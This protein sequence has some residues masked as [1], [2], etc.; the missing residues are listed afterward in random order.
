M[1]DIFP[2]INAIGVELEGGWN[3]I[4]CRCHPLEHDG[5]VRVEADY[6]TGEIP[7]GPLYS[8]TQAETEIR[9][10]YPHVTNRT[11]GLHVHLSFPT[12]GHYSAIMSPRFEN[13]LHRRLMLYGKRKNFS[14]DGQFFQRLTGRN[15]YCK[16]R[17]TDRN[18]MTQARSTYK[19]GERYAFLNYCHG[20]HGTVELR[21]LPAFLRVNSALRAIKY[22]LES[23][24][25]FL[26]LPGA[27]VPHVEED[28]AYMPDAADGLADLAERI[29]AGAWA[30][31]LR[32]EV[33]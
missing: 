20:L 24:E 7:L 19:G 22:T 11:C 18:A 23:F 3:T 30:S 26:S 6:A 4:P 32:T 16:T 2:N 15:T 13:F 12:P 17:Y 8:W 28:S 33:R 9:Q 25:R 31:E 21:A 10:H 5:S 29:D 27:L 1:R 14:P